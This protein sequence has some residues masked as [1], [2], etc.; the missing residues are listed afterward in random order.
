MS[1]Q[2]RAALAAIEGGHIVGGSDLVLASNWLAL[3]TEMQKIARAAL[4]APPAD[5]VPDMVLVPRVATEVMVTAALDAVQFQASDLKQQE[6]FRAKARAV[7]AA[8]VAAAERDGGH[9]MD[10]Y[11]RGLRDGLARA[12]GG[13]LEARRGDPKPIPGTGH[14][15]GKCGKCGSSDLWDDNGAYGCNACGAF[16]C[17]FAR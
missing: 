11:E 2:M 16:W 3:V 7:W 15:T 14:Y 1:E 6:L 10:D 9:V 12:S 17:G 4:A 5:A 8:L 13:R